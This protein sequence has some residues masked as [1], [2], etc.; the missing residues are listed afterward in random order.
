MKKFVICTFLVFGLSFVW[1][2]FHLAT[3]DLIQ[4][5]GMDTRRFSIYS[6]TRYQSWHLTDLSTNTETRLT[7]ISIPWVIFYPVSN[8]TQILISQ[9]NAISDWRLERVD[10]RVQADVPEIDLEGFGDMRFKLTHVLPNGLLVLLGVNFPTSDKSEL[11]DRETLVSNALYEESLDF[12]AGR[13]GGG[14][15]F[16]IGTAYARTLAGVTLGAG[17]NYLYKGRYHKGS[18]TC[19]FD[20]PTGTLK[21]D[22]GDEL[23]ITGGFNLGSEMLQ[24]RSDFIYTIHTKEKF[25]G[26]DCFKQGPD[27]IV[28]SGLIYTKHRLQLALSGQRVWRGKS[29]RPNDQD[30]LEL[31]FADLNNRFVF[32]LSGT[33]RVGQRTTIGGSVENKRLSENEN[34]RGAANVWALGLSTQFQVTRILRLTFG[35]KISDGELTN[36][37]INLSGLG[38]YGALNTAF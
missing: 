38:Y 19:G 15:G 2:G 20:D 17:I 27:F 18:Y 31:P 24:W 25:G 4:E 37:K 32:I 6:T 28:D 1:E 22:P 10:N 8:R 26:H 33:Y 3:A 11:D 21:Y 12:R 29:K 7:Q 36:E 14:W 16:D 35:V 23:N 13:L 34:K 30:E 9:L 5:A